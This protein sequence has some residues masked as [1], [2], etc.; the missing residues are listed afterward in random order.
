MHNCSSCNRLILEETAEC[1]FCSESQDKGF[2]IPRSVKMLGA[3]ATAFVMAACYG[4]GPMDYKE[5]GMDTGITLD[6]DED[7]FNSDVDCDDTNAEINPEASEVCDDGVDNDCDD[8]ID[9]DDTDCQEDSAAKSAA[10]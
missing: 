8:A 3:S 9:S 5:T 6:L 4:V 7:G 10:K 2:K 1:P